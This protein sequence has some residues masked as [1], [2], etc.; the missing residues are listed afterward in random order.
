MRF[1]TRRSHAANS[2]TRDRRVRLGFQVLEERL[3]LTTLP[4]GFRETLITTASDLSA[5]TAM[6]FSPTGQL[7]VLEQAGAAKLIRADGTAHTALALTVDSAGER[8]LLG[9]A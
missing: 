9:I 5:A 4:A 8:G 1:R 6:E 2:R 7:W 3:A